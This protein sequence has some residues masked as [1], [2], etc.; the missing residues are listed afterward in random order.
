MEKVLGVNVAKVDLAKTFTNAYAEKAN[1][2]EGFKTSTTPATS[3][4]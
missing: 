2:L 4:G 3:A 1:K